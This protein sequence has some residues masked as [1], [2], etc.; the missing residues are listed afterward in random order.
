[1]YRNLIGDCWI[2]YD[3]MQY[4]SSNEITLKHKNIAH[5]ITASRIETHDCVTI[6][7]LL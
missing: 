3:I 1:M 5:N 7:K 2:P 6:V 4:Y